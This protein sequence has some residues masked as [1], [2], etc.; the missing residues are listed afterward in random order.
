MFAFDQQRGEQNLHLL[1]RP[2]ERDRLL[3]SCLRAAGNGHGL[4]GR[5]PFLVRPQQRR[6]SAL[7]LTLL[8]PQHARRCGVHIHDLPLDVAD[9]NPHRQCTQRDH[10]LF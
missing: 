6:I 8:D 9:H 4:Y 5:S 10:A 1:G 3:G 2:L 7:C